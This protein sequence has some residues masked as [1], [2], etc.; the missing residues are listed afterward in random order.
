MAGKPTVFEQEQREARMRIQDM[1]RRDGEVRRLKDKVNRL[2]HLLELVRD[3]LLTPFAGSL[4]AKISD[5]LILD[6]EEMDA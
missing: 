6:P 1:G 2:R 3:E 4:E 5:A